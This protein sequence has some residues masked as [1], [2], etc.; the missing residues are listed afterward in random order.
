MKTL[1]T[2]LLLTLTTSSFAKDPAKLKY[3][4]DFLF[5]KVLEKKRQTKNPAIA[6]PNIYFSSKTPLKQ[7]QDA[8]EGQWGMRPDF[9]TNAYAVAN[10]EI[11]IS[12][13]PDYYESQKRCMDDSLVHELV[14]YVQVKYLNW[15]LN[16]ESLEWDAIE[17]QTA[18]REEFCPVL[19]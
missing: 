1:I 4:V 13:D 16:D 2:I 5:S 8:I 3:Q 10:N 11:Y 12:D 17:I 6:F 18:F 15:D 19:K 14:H 9:I 7:F